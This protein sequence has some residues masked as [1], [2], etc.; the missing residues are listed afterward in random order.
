MGWA[1]AKEDLA[2][3]A[4]V[5]VHRVFFDWEALDEGHLACEVSSHLLL[6]IA[7]KVRVVEFSAYEPFTCERGRVRFHG[8]LV[9]PCQIEQFL[10]R[11]MLQDET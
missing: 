8:R 7:N 3:Q 11:K 10:A 5:A 6:L 4:G 2:L 9:N 1:V